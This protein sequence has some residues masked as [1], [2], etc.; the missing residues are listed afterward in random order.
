M[1]CFKNG[2]GAKKT[3]LEG[4]VA[5]HETEMMKP[6]VKQANDNRYTYSILVLVMIFM[7]G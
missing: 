5:A 6:L 7:V 1:R 4:F 2:N 3:G